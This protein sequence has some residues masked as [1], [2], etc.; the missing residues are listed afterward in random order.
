[1][2]YRATEFT[3]QRKAQ[4][5]ARLLKEAKKLVS[6]GG[7]RSLSIAEVARRSAIATGTVYR[8][9]PSK[10]ELCVAVFEAATQREIEAVSHAGLDAGDAVQQLQQALECFIQRAMLNPNLAYALI[11][12]PVDPELEQTRLNYRA[13]WAE[14]FAQR[15]EQGMQQGVFISQP[16]TLCATALV[17][18][19]AETVILPLQ[20]A[21]SQN[22][23]YA[24][25]QPLNQDHCLHIIAFCLR[26]VVKPENHR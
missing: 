25:N 12:E 11:A 1:M 24:T 21:R 6:A 23:A 10:S 19:M 15:L 20:Q 17:G 13:Q 22:P 2:A 5:R 7:F 4:T 14:V 26:A 9:F 8:Y 3:E 18:A 16:A